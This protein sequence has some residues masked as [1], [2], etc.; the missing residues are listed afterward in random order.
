MAK[1]NGPLPTNAVRVAVTHAPSDV[2]TWVIA[3]RDSGQ[4]DAWEWTRD[5]ARPE[6]IVR[7]EPQSTGKNQLIL[8]GVMAPTTTP[9]GK[10]RGGT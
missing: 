6:Y 4:L 1:S 3:V 10:G 7:S 2:A 9:S 5:P 8:Y